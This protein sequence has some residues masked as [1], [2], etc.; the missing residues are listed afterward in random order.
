MKMLESANGH[1]HV[2]TADCH[3]CGWTQ[4]LTKV[5]RQQRAHF[6][7][8]RSFRWLC[9]ECVA[10]LQASPQP[11]LAP[12]MKTDAHKVRAGSRSVA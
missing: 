12:A 8:G 7:S 5:T 9:S 1:A 4:P 10:D 3:R 2:R 11:S 6:S